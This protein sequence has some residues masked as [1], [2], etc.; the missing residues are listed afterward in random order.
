[1]TALEGADLISVVEEDIDAP[2]IDAHENFAQV[3][4]AAGPGDLE[5]LVS[6]CGLELAHTRALGPCRRPKG[7][8]LGGAGCTCPLGYR[9][10]ASA[11]AQPSRSVV[12][13]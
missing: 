13:P 6:H 8:W 3:T 4:L 7:R 2:T 5:D 9:H 10:S 1:V 12:H 11:W